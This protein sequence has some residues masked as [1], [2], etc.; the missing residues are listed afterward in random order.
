MMFSSS[1]KRLKRFVLKSYI[2]S[3]QNRE[4]VSLYI[5]FSFQEKEKLAEENAKIKQELE[6]AKSQISSLK[7]RMSIIKNIDSPTNPNMPTEEEENDPN[8]ISH[9]QNNE[10][11]P[12]NDSHKKDSEA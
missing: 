8:I 2:Y 1:L 12:N 9:D 7:E 4:F 3:F 6:S 5:R 10:D 11:E